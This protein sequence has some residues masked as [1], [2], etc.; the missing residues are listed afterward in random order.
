MEHP[1]IAVMDTEIIDAECTEL[2]RKLGAIMIRGN[3]LGLTA[4]DSPHGRALTAA[5]YR[6]CD[7]LELQGPRSERIAL[8][9][10]EA[11]DRYELALGQLVVKEDETEQLYCVEWCKW[12][13]GGGVDMQEWK[14]SPECGLCLAEAEARVKRLDLQ[15]APHFRHRYVEVKYEP[16][17]G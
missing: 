15:F 1:N 3:Q 9:L 6:A 17:S 7:Q 13:H 14:S 8:Q 11:L 16:A 12:E 10:L 5:V 4:E 2:Q